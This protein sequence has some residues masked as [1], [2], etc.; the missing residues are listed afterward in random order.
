MARTTL[1]GFFKAARCA[2]VARAIESEGLLGSGDTLHLACC[3][4]DCKNQCTDK[5][6]RPKSTGATSSLLSCR[7][8][9]T[10]V[11]A[12]I[13]AMV[14]SGMLD[15]GQKSGHGKPAVFGDDSPQDWLDCGFMIFAKA[16]MTRRHVLV[17][18][19]PGP[20][21]LQ[22][23]AQP[24]SHSTRPIMPPSIRSATLQDLPA[25]V[26]LLIQDAE[27]R[28]SL[29]PV[30]WR[31]AGDASTR[32]ER[33]VGA[34]LNG[35]QAPAREFWFVAERVGRIVGVTHAMLVPVPPIY[36]GAAG[37]PGLLLDDC[38][39]A[40]GAPSGTAE[41]LLVATEAALE[42]A[43][44]PRLIASSPAAGPLRLLYERHGYE[45]VTLYMA[46]HR[47]SPD[48]LPPSVRKASAEDVPG[49]VKRS[50][51]HRRMLARINP[52]FWHI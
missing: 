41:A 4:A 38:F 3:R 2:G 40:A 30:L 32:I 6:L 22:A 24:A 7:H 21:P 36:D 43:G 39:I 50:A 17:A 28:R 49:I 13:L 47:P 29:D 31:T 37:S 33:A 16:R 9:Q 14:M 20:C 10:L 1:L 8:S 12:L 5:Y 11:G 15:S 18:A 52:R 44:A 48:A 45:P 26:E 27:A 42:T 25:I 35:S 23:V 19:A 34:V 51:E 46:K